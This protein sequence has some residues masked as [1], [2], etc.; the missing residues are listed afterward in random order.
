MTVCQKHRFD[1]PDYGCHV[2]L[3]GHDRKLTSGKVSW[4]ATQA[5]IYRS[6]RALRAR[7]RKKSLKKGLFGGR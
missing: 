3:A 4:L 6:L 2:V 5:A 7:N 1:N